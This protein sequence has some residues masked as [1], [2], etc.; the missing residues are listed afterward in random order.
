MQEKYEKLNKL[1]SEVLVLSRNTLLVNLRFLDS[2][3][4]RLDY[5]P[6][7]DSYLLTEGTHIFYNP[8]YVLDCYKIEKEMSVR[9]YLH[10]TLHCSFRHIYP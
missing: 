3:L 1:A 6:I 10:I 5:F 2:A 9:D 4:S 8:K 7:D